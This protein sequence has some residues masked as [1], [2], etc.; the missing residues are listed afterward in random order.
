MLATATL[1]ATPAL[2]PVQVVESANQIQHD[3]L[4]NRL[5][6]TS[7]WL[8]AQ[9]PTTVTIQLM[10]IDNETQLETELILLAQKIERDNIHVYRTKI[11]NSALVERPYFTVLYGSFANRQKAIQE[12]Q[13]LPTSIQKNKPQLRTIA[14]ILQ[15][16]K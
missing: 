2:T 6:A 1:P 3:A 9:S 13:K 12:M 10:G 4:S 8:L 15:E 7:T 16:T 5:Q 14:G 11:I